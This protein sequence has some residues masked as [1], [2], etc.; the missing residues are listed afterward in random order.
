MENSVFVLYYFKKKNKI[1]ENNVNCNFQLKCHE[2]ETQLVDKKLNVRILHRPK[3]IE[4]MEQLVLF[5]FG[6]TI[7]E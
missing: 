6:A 5:A 1:V 4:E 2:I 7:A 3:G